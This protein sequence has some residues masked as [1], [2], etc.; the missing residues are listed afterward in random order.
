MIMGSSKRGFA[1]NNPHEVIIFTKPYNLIISSDKN[2]ILL[3][4]EPLD[5]YLSVK[6]P[7]ITERVLSGMLSFNTLTT[8]LKNAAS[9][10]REITGFDRVMVYRFAK[11]GHG[12]VVA[13]SKNRNLTS[14]LGLHYPASDIPLQARELYKRNL[15]RLIAD[16]YA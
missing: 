3:E 8:L 7:H 10:V 13:E 12:E 14:W 6:M 2:Y 1:T 15:T 5:S 16:V 11:D 9:E 4:F